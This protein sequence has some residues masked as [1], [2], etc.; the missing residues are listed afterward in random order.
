MAGRQHAEKPI[1]RRKPAGKPMPAA[2]AG[3][4]GRRS[5]IHA[6]FEHVF[7]HQKNASVSSSAPSDWRA[8]TRRT[9]AAMSNLMVRKL[10]AHFAG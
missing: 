4:N 3:A 7:A 6:R 10:A 8:P 5:S 9:R 2:T 1:H